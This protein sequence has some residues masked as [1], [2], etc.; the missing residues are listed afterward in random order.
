MDIEEM[1]KDTIDYSFELFFDKKSI[2]SNRS[3]K[4]KDDVWMGWACS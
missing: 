4:D 1:K 3:K 2:D